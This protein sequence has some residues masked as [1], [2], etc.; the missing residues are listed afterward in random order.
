MK[1]ISV[2]LLKKNKF[3]FYSINIIDC[4]CGYFI[5]FFLSVVITFIFFENLLF[6]VFISIPIGFITIN[7][8]NDFKLKVYKKKLL[9]EF[10]DFLESLSTSYLSGKNTYNAFEDS[11]NDMVTLH[12]SSACMTK[13]I[14][15]III[16][17]NNGAN[18]DIL[19]KKFAY[20]SQINDIKSFSNVFIT[21]NKMG[22]NLSKVI[23]E[24][25]EIIN[26]KIEIEMNI[27]TLVTQKKLEFYIMCIM[28]FI[29]ILL[30]KLFGDSTFDISNGGNVFIR[31]ISLIVLVISFFV[32]KKI[33]DIKF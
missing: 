1:K 10:K 6:S 25:K 30:L 28:P 24:T 4:I 18:I 21:C 31:I 2:K 26:D 12:G 27:K 8:Y 19:L 29:I 32:G 33:T 20:D 23:N 11:Y 17:L 7:Y 16:G 3:S 15:K 14:K 13:C 22:G 5:G 9:L